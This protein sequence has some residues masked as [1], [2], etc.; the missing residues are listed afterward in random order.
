[1]LHTLETVEIND[2]SNAVGYYELRSARIWLGQLTVDFNL[3]R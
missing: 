2:C 3:V 1:L